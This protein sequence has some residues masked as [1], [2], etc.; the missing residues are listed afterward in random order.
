MRW[1]DGWARALLLAAA[2]SRVVQ[3]TNYTVTITPSTTGGWTASNNDLQLLP[4]PSVVGF[5][6]PQLSVGDQLVIS[7]NTII[8]AVG[9]ASCAASTTLVCYPEMYWAAPQFFGNEGLPTVAANVVG[10]VTVP[11]FQKCIVNFTACSAATASGAFAGAVTITAVSTR[12][13]S[14]ALSAPQFWGPAS[15]ASSSTPF[16]SC[17]GGSNTTANS[18][19]AGC[20]NG[21]TYYQ[22]ADAAARLGYSQFA[23]GNPTTPSAGSGSYC[24]FGNG[25]TLTSATCPTT[26]VPPSCAN[27]CGSSTM[28]WVYSQQYP[29]PMP[30]SPPRPPP[31]PPSPPLPAPPS[32]PAA[33]P[34]PSKP[35]YKKT[36]WII[37]MAGG[38]AGV[39]LVVGLIIAFVCW[40]Q[41]RRRA[42][43]REDEEAQSATPTGSH[44]S[45][46]FLATRFGKKRMGLRL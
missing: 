46:G 42:R 19:S 28:Y 3:A 26:N 9:G 5:A 37:I 24:Y 40:R 12:T 34:S 20:V 45:M 14:T 44:A 39:L 22:C 25:V 31:S 35:W 10:A 6:L 27:M 8:V 18:N 16:P 2:C 36:M 38:G 1:G 17:W 33:A 15:C 4:T 11:G 21:A 13:L 41:R 32:P 29:P 7:S 43:Q 23:L 30:P